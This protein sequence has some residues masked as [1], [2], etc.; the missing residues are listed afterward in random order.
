MYNYFKITN[1]NSC[2]HLKKIKGKHE[3]STY[4]SHRAISSQETM[5]NN[6]IIPTVTKQEAMTRQ[7]KKQWRP[8]NEI[9]K[10]INCSLT[11]SGQ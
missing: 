1:G 7:N 6:L 8:I 9:I 4:H 2:N 5:V 3:E 10:S 11:S